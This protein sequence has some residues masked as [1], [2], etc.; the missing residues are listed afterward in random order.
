MEVNSGYKQVGGYL[1]GQD[2]YKFWYETFSNPPNQNQNDIYP[3]NPLI[4]FGSHQLPQEPPD[5]KNH[6]L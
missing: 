5:Y 6:P 1:G 3:K 2:L 4:Y